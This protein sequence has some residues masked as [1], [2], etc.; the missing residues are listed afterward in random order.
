MDETGM[1]KPLFSIMG[2]ENNSNNKNFLDETG[3]KNP[4]FIGNNSNNNN[5]LDETGIQ[6]PIRKI[7]NKEED[8][9][10]MLDEISKVIL[11]LQTDMTKVLTGINKLNELTTKIKLARLNKKNNMNNNNNMMNNNINNNI[12]L[13]MF[14]AMNNMIKLNENP[15]L[16]N[17]NVINIFFKKGALTT[18]INCK[19]NEKISDVINRYMM[20]SSDTSIYNRYIYNGKALNHSLTVG[21]S[22]ITNNNYVYVM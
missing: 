16:N 4:L 22:G 12:M 1:D 19:Q 5:F 20:K 18:I 14:N 3:M 11:N 15:F 10:D 21:Q 9:D 2:R 13:P 6:N 8:I 7:M 17:S